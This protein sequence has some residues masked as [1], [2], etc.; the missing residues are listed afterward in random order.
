MD[1]N[2]TIHQ[3]LPQDDFDVEKA[4]KEKE[5]EKETDLMLEPEKESSSFEKP[6]RLED[7]KCI[8]CLS[9]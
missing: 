2:K 5:K 8:R 9:L 7:D 4:L 1:L 6:N 3:E